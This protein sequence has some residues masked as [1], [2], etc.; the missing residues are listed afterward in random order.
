MYPDNI[1]QFSYKHNSTFLLF[2]IL[3][4][5]AERDPNDIFADVCAV[6]DK[7]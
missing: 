3:Q 6:L 5:P 1:I 4:I 7:L 2:Y